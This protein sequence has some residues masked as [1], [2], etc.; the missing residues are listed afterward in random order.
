MLCREIVTLF[1]D[2]YKMHKYKEFLNVEADGAYKW[3]VGFTKLNEL[4]K[5]DSAPWNE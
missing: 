1:W 2:L 4:L 3:P 5:K